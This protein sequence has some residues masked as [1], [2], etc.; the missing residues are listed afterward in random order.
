MTKIGGQPHW[1]STLNPGVHVCFLCVMLYSI[2]TAH[3]YRLMFNKIL[4]T[5]QFVTSINTPSMHSV[6]PDISPIDSSSYHIQVTCSPTSGLPSS[7][8]HVS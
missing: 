1:V 4:V 5:Q 7:T 2:I 8:T 3:G 6:T